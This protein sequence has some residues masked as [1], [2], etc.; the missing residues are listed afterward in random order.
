MI[1]FIIGGFWHGAGWTFIILGAMHGTALIVHRIWSNLGYKLNK[2]V[3][4]F[5]TLNFVNIA[6]IFF[7]SKD[8]N[9]A[10]SILL[11]MFGAN[12]KSVFSFFDVIT[13]I[14]V[15]FALII[16]LGAV[17][18]CFCLQN[19]N[20]AN[21]IFRPNAHYRIL[22]IV[23]L[24]VDFYISAQYNPRNF[25]ILI[26]KKF[27]FQ[28]IL[29]T[30]AIY[31]LLVLYFVVIDDYGLFFKDNRKIYTAENERTSK[32]LFTYNYIPSYFNGLLLGSS[33][34]DQ[35][36]TS[37]LKGYEIFNLS[38]NG[39]NTTEL[40]IL[41][42]NVLKQEDQ[43]KVIILTLHEYVTETSGRKTSH[44]VPQEFYASFSSIDAVKL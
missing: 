44:M 1:T 10:V 31:F 38:M 5:L 23:V 20:L 28:S 13:K 35:I 17:I 22:F 4:W 24:L 27:M 16:T 29:A 19:L 40:Y 39:A 15:P 2:M 18:G 14:D 41:L 7:R 25:Y 21:K 6:W 32:Y 43:I 33:L 30:A 9:D 3:A 34:G 8:L 37:L 42:N 11:V 36:N 12:T 26:F